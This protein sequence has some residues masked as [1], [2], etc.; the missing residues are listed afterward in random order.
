MASEYASRVYK[1]R[2]YLPSRSDYA[3]GTH[4]A[5]SYT[6]YSDYA[7]GFTETNHQQTLVK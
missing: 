2:M 5:E 7:D 3:D 4:T 6:K 1:L